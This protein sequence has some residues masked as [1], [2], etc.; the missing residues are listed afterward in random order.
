LF[1]SLHAPFFFWLQLSWCYPL[2]LE[3][4]REENFLMRE[5]KKK[6]ELDAIENEVRK[7]VSQGRE[8]PFLLL[9]LS[10]G[11]HEQKKRE[12]DIGRLRERRG[13]TLRMQSLSD[14]INL[15]N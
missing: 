12:I 15:N 10:N 6:K 3:E 8:P 4:R 5:N 9:C 1:S 7:R 14:C 11:A 13:D 2:R